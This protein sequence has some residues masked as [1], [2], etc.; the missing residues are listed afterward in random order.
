MKKFDKEEAGN[1]GL[2]IRKKIVSYDGM[3]AIIRSVTSAFSRAEENILIVGA[4]T[5]EELNYLLELN[6]YVQIDALEP[7]TNMASFL[8]ERIFSK[9]ALNRVEVINK[10]LEEFSSSKKYGLITSILVSHFI[11]NDEKKAYFEKMKMLLAH[12]GNIVLVDA[13]SDN[14]LK[15]V[16]YNYLIWVESLRLNGFS[17]K[18]ISSIEKRY[19]ESFY[20]INEEKLKSICSDVGL[21]VKEHF[22]RSL[23]FRGYL[24]G[25]C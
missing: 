14:D 6:D 24:I 12:N 7:S 17:G 23:H 15:N 11:S 1:Y 3:H 2:D 10:K 9:N 13:F 22:F 20:P 19:R 8:L 21:E 25:H 18:E 4:G 5:G 16:D